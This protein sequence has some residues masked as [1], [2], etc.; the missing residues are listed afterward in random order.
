MHTNIRIDDRDAT[1]RTSDHNPDGSGD[2]AAPQDRA[3]HLT[4]IYKNN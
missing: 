2:A 3:G 4:V 1:D